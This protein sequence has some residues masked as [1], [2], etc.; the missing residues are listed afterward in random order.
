MAFC[1]AVLSA[2]PAAAGPMQLDGKFAVSSSG[3]ATYHIPMAVPP[4]TAG[5]M[6]NL[7]LDYDNQRGD[8]IVGVGWSL[9]GFSAIRRCAQT[10]TQDGADGRVGYDTSD[11]YCLDGQRLMVITGT[12]GADLSEY[13]TEIESFTK[14]IAH[15]TAGNGPSWFEVHLPSGRVLEFGNTPD[16]K[17][18]AVAK[19]SVRVWALN[20]VTDTKGN[21]LKVTYSNDTTN[22]SYYPTLIDYTGNTA[23]ALTPYAQVQ[24]IY[25]N[26]PTTDQV[27]TYVAGSKIVLNKELS[28]IKTFTGGAQV[29]DYK[30]AYEAAVNTA[31]GAARL[32]S[33][34]MCDAAALCQPATTFTWSNGPAATVTYG[35]WQDWL[36]APGTAASSKPTLGRDG[37]VS[38]ATSGNFAYIRRAPS[39]SSKATLS[40]L[41]GG[42]VDINGDGRTDVLINNNGA[43][44]VTLST[45][46]GFTALASTGITAYSPQL[47]DIF[48]TG[49]SDIVAFNASNQIVRYANTNTGPG[50]FNTTAT[51]LFS[52]AVGHPVFP[53][54]Y[55]PI[56]SDLNGDG[57]PDAVWHSSSDVFK[58]ALNTGTGFAAA[59][60][61][62]RPANMSGFH[63][64]GT[65]A[66]IPGP[67]N[68]FGTASVQFG[69]LR[70]RGNTDIIFTFQAICPA[71]SSSCSGGDLREW[72]VW[73][74]VWNGT[75]YSAP[76]KVVSFA[77]ATSQQNCGTVGMPV[78]CPNAFPQLTTR[79]T[80][81]NGDGLS[82]LYIS[83]PAL[84]V[85]G[86][87]YPAGR[88]FY[89][90]NGNAF[91]ASVA[92]G[93]DETSCNL[94][95]TFTDVYASGGTD[96]VCDHSDA[97]RLARPNAT[98]T[99]FVTQTSLTAA[100]ATGD[101][102]L[103]DFNGDGFPDFLTQANSN[104]HY[105]VALSNRVGN[106]PVD[107]LTGITTGLGALTTISYDALSH[108][109][110]LYTKGTVG[111]YPT[112][113][114]TP[115]TYVVT[116]VDRSNG[117]GGNFSSSYKYAGAQFDVR[118]RGYLGLTGFTS[119]DL[120]TNV[121]TA[122][123]YRLDY[124]YT[125]LIA[126]DV[127]SLG[128]VTLS[129]V[130]SHYSATS[131][132]ATRYFPFLTDSLAQ[133]ADLDGS[134][135]PSVTMT[136]QYDT[137]GNPTL[138]TSTTSDGFTK[139]ST[140]TYTNDT[141]HWILGLL[142]QSQVTSSTP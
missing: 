116:R 71:G 31:T 37:G 128:A 35:T 32:T 111:T 4:G 132:G 66:C 11:R 106:A 113:D 38:G 131:L 105:W 13:R 85:S 30:L 82:D 3:G 120:G 61:I 60:T 112:L 98:A 118:G 43:L 56:F 58:F 67:D 41:N 100:A 36:T 15:G 52:P 130:V 136:Y 94:G 91:N 7:S 14:V 12:Y 103:K 102:W 123:T 135:Y 107:L 17:I 65:G 64:G 101:W 55:T 50:W 9:G 133:G 124:P 53:D 27:A 19:T 95:L 72:N 54:I 129:N 138:V 115:N 6:P 28:E 23:A 96:A 2:P 90:G 75:G 114:T 134:A 122:T 26:R 40:N 63:C 80:D 142:T 97:I 92:P 29:L 87:N 79:I 126:S 5:M 83:Y 8:G 68:T 110:T 74:A 121:Q 99:G 51:V 117:I 141:T 48:G 42:D 109:P 21:F 104:N 84:S 108:D 34:Q 69:N 33:V 77:D 76:V 47:I 139:T 89:I 70:G 46:T 140:N 25:V 59:Q 78:P 127:K 93:L 1:A 18:L 44:S 16:S 49:R 20:K 22:G 125:G 73:Y 86:H 62:T 39:G 81:I 24:L 57:L 10:F 88:F 119:T 45:G 137:F